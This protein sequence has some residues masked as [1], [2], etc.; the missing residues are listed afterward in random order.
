MKRKVYTDGNGSKHILVEGLGEYSPKADHDRLKADK[1]ELVDVIKQLDK[2]YCELV[3]SGDAGNWNP[4]DEEI[5]KLAR[6]LI[7]KHKEQNNE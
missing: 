3:D 2:H 6:K 5:I 4:N 7:Q 1:A